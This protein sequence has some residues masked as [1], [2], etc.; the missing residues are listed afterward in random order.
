MEVTILFHLGHNLLY[1]LLDKGLH[2]SQ[3]QFFFSQKKKQKNV[4]SLHPKI[5]EAG[6]GRLVAISSQQLVVGQNILLLL[7]ISTKL[8]QGFWERTLI[9]WTNHNYKANILLP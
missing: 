8:T 2:Q 5:R 7:P 4:C 9:N 6:T 3:L 1:L